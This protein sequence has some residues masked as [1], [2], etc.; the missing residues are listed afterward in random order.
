[1]GLQPKLIT[2]RKIMKTLLV[3]IGLSILIYLLDNKVVH[4][5]IRNAAKKTTN[6]VDDVAAES[7]VKFLKDVGTLLQKK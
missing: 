2:R 1:M 7:V 6:E 4:E 5:A 3:K